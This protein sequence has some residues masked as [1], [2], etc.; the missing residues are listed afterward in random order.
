MLSAENI[1]KLIF[2]GLYKHDPVEDWVSP[3]MRDNMYWCRNWTFR[4]IEVNCKYYMQDT[5]FNNKSIELT[6]ENFDGFKFVL[7][8]NDVVRVSEKIARNYSDEDR[9]HIAVDSGGLNDKC[10]FI[11]RGAHE[12]IEQ[13]I[14]NINEEIADLQIKLTNKQALLEV[15]MKKLKEEV[16]HVSSGQC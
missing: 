8:F 6:D 12:N 10:W 3:G 9:Y 15:Y 13:V 11:K 14:R 7:D 2:T 5:Y 4:P 1:E 16:E